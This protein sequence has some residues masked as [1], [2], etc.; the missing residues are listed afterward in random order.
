MAKAKPAPGL[1]AGFWLADPYLP[2]RAAGRLLL[3]GLYS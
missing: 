2:L 1:G 3:A